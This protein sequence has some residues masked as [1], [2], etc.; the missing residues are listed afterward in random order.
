MTTERKVTLLNERN[1][2]ARQM[3]QQW[4]ISRIEGEPKCILEHWQVLDVLPTGPC[5]F[6]A[7]GPRYV[8]FAGCTDRSEI[9]HL[10]REIV[11][12]DSTRRAGLT[13]DGGIYELGRIYG[14]SKSMAINA[15]RG[16]WAYSHKP[17]DITAQVLSMLGGQKVYANN[18]T[19]YFE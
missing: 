8:V 5:H 6:P 3:A 16:F 18:E 1:R 12:F 4:N 15:S 7:A 19:D 11:R 17:R 9:L 2:K 14:F 10:S 13:V